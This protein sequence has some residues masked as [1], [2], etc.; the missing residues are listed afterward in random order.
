MQKS[1][2][3]SGKV[4]FLNVLVFFSF[5]FILIMKFLVTYDPILISVLYLS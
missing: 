3:V 1:L 5:F 2:H 4:I